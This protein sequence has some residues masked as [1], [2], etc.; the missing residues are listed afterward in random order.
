MQYFFGINITNND[1]ELLILV[2][3][4]W[5][6]HWYVIMYCIKSIERS[7]HTPIMYNV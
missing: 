6:S 3:L 1:Y 5:N 2:V 4:N 7:L